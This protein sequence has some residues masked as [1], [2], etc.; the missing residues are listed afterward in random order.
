MKLST[1]QLISQ[2][3]SLLEVKF[4]EH[5][6]KAQ[7]GCYSFPPTQPWKPLSKV[8]S[9]VKLFSSLS[10]QSSFPSSHQQESVLCGLLRPNLSDL[11][12]GLSF[13]AITRYLGSFSFLLYTSHSRE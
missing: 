11:T 1:K 7:R 8:D 4:Q 12:S 3:F 2:C 5:I 6:V 10:L 13:H 9:H